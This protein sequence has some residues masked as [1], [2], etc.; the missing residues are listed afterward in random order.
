MQG[1]EVLR[2]LGALDAAGIQAAITGGWGIDALLGRQTRLHSDVDLGLSVDDVEVAIEAL[3]RSG[4]RVVDDQRPARLSLASQDGQVDLHPIR[5][6]ESGRG[7][8]TGFGETFEYPPGSL[9]EEGR[10]EGQKVR[11]GTPELQVTF[12][13]GYEP[14]LHDRQDMKALAETFHMALPPDYSN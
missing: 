2:V 8:Q 14:K 5:F 6:D 4:Y 9:E 13:L 10:I 1:S 11:C 3:R 7:L 12:H